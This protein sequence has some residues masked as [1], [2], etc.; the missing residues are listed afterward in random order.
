MICPEDPTP[1]LVG[2]WEHLL[3]ANATDLNDRLRDSLR[4][5]PNE[6]FAPRDIA[7]PAELGFHP[8]RNPAPPMEPLLL[9]ADERVRVSAVLA[10]HAPMAPAY[11]LRF[12]IDE[13]YGGGS[14]VVSGDTAP[15]DNVIT[16]SHRADVLL[17]EVIDEVWIHERVAALGTES[18]RALVDHH[19]G[20]HTTV[21]QAAEVADRAEVDRLVL[22]HFVPGNNPLHRWERIHEHFPRAVVGHDLMRLQ[23]AGDRAGVR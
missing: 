23:L 19:R 11:A 17:H 2:T 5:H 20:A 18:A 4:P 13:E 9:H 15:C 14:V 3:A 22:H 8:D 7:L 21:A 16:L 1:G 10:S 6:L 12:D